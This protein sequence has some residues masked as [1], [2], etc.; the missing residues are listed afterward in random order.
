MSAVKNKSNSSPS[1]FR[2]LNELVRNL[3]VRM[4]EWL[5]SSVSKKKLPV[6]VISSV[7][8]NSI[9]T[10]NKLLQVYLEQE[11]SVGHFQ[12]SRC[13]YL[14]L[15]SLNGIGESLKPLQMSLVWA[16]PSPGSSAYQGDYTCQLSI[17][18]QSLWPLAQLC[19]LPLCLFNLLPHFLACRSGTCTMSKLA[20][21]FA[22]R[23]FSSTR[24]HTRM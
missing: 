11:G 24:G 17:A 14:E 13:K 10:S 19:P 1:N 20:L 9:F 3:A 12:V 2:K 21:V 15:T 4:N 18:E 7:G 8:W 5:N 16:R 23:L 22:Q 6:A